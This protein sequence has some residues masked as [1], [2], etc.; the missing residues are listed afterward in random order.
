MYVLLYEHTKEG[1]HRELNGSM[2]LRSKRN[3]ATFK[4]VGCVE[5]NDFPKSETLIIIIHIALKLP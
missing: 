3:L 5:N 1:L 4:N 2:I